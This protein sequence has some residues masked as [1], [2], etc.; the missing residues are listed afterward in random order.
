MSR[1]LQVFLYALIL[2]IGREIVAWGLEKLNA[3]DWTYGALLIFMFV[4]WLIGAS[5]I[6]FRK[7]KP[8]WADS[9]KPSE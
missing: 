5:K 7:R 3:P 4:A 1:I 6:L 2:L 9:P 8:K